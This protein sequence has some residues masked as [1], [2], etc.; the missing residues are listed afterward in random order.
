MLKWIIWELLE[1]SFFRAHFPQIHQTEI[2]SLRFPSERKDEGPAL[3]LARSLSFPWEIKTPKGHCGVM[4]ST[5]TTPGTARALLSPESQDKPQ[6]LL[7]GCFIAA[8]SPCSPL[9]HR[10]ARILSLKPSPA[11]GCLTCS[12]STTAA[13]GLQELKEKTSPLRAERE[14]WAESEH[15]D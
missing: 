8:P 11:L 3:N 9:R 7:R 4:G 10:G 15:H 6:G 1:F 12:H 13:V 14:C 2:T 5:K